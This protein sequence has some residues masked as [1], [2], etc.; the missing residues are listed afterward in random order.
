MSEKTTIS[1]TDIKTKSVKKKTENESQSVLKDDATTIKKPANKI[2][3]PKKQIKAKVEKATVNSSEK[4]GVV[5]GSLSNDNDKIIT[6]EEIPKIDAKKNKKTKVDILAIS[7]KEEISVKKMVKTKVVVLYKLY[8]YVLILIVAIFVGVSIILIETPI[9]SK[10]NLPMYGGYISRA[11][12]V[13]NLN[14]IDSLRYEIEIWRH[15]NKNITD[16]IAG[17]KAI[18]TRDEISNIKEVMIAEK[19]MES[20]SYE[21]VL[22]QRVLMD[23]RYEV[24]NNFYDYNFHPPLRGQIVQ[25]FKHKNEEG[26]LIEVYNHNEVLSINDGTVIVSMYD[27][28]Y[29]NVIQIQHSDDMISSYSY[30]SI[31]SKG[32][33]DKVLSGEVIGYVGSEERDVVSLSNSAKKYKL[34]FVLWHKGNRVNPENY[35][36]F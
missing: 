15:Y 29:G 22:K 31:G 1:K 20:S 5:L 32:V 17:E 26:V 11:L 25:D 18:L 9:L 30:L 2:N 19:N 14:K 27:P 8:L 10:L 13:D 36:V 6:T 3:A 23:R 12:I 16:I 34:Y 35:I 33:G 28:N 21:D 24:R 4:N 7:D